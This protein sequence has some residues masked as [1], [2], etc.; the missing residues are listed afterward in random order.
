M[1]NLEETHEAELDLIL[2]ELS[3][4]E[5]H[6][7]CGGGNSSNTTNVR[8]QSGH[9]QIAGADGVV[10]RHGQTHSR[11]NSILSGVTNTSNSTSSESG[12]GSGSESSGLLRESRTDSPDNDSA[13]SDTV[14]LLSSASSSASSGVSNFNHRKYVFPLTSNLLYVSHGEQLVHILRSK[15]SSK[16]IEKDKKSVFACTLVFV[17]FAL[18]TFT[19]GVLFN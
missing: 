5:Q 4:L 18:P 9:L 1:A 17:L 19:F 14:S 2:G 15:S 13:F 7:N 11:S 12:T 6:N 3:M 10:V 8:N 16:A